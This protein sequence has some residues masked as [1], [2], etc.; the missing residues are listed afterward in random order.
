MKVDYIDYT[1]DTS[2]SSDSSYLSNVNYTT[3][4]ALPTKPEIKVKD[5]G[6]GLYARAQGESTLYKLSDSPIYG[7][8]LYLDLNEWDGNITQ[9]LRL[10]SKTYGWIERHAYLRLREEI[11]RARKVKLE[12]KDREKALKGAKTF[13]VRSA[14]RIENVKFNGPATIVFWSDG[15]KTVVKCGENDSLDREKGLAMAI[16]KR[17]LGN[18][19]NYLNEFKRWLEKKDE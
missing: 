2:T 10:I 11:V 19:G 13:R 8:Y 6:N 5:L 16:S 12:R 4:T 18:Q 9:T 17:M 7:E 3:C 14:M 1:W 15:T